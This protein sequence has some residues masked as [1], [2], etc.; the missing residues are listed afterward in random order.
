MGLNGRGYCH[1]GSFAPLTNTLY[2][3]NGDGTFTDVSAETGISKVAGRG[4]GVAFRRL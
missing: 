3:N 4:M 1:P 2:R